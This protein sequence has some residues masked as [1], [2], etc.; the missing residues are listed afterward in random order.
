MGCNNGKASAP[1]PHAGKPA[2]AK[3]LLLGNEDPAASA[4]VATSMIMEVFTQASSLPG[5]SAGADE[6]E[7]NQIQEAH[8]A[9]DTYKELPTE[10]LHNALRLSPL[11]IVGVWQY[12]GKHHG[13][14]YEISIHGDNLQI[15]QMVS[16]TLLRGILRAEGEWLV[17]HVQNAEFFE[18]GTLRL[19]HQPQDR[20]QFGKLLSNFKVTGGQWGEDFMSS[21]AGPSSSLATSSSPVA[22]HGQNSS[23]TS[24][25]TAL[26]SSLATPSS[27]T[28]AQ[29]QGSSMTSPC[30]D[31]DKA[32][33]HKHNAPQVLPALNAGD[34]HRAGEA[35]AARPMDACKHSSDL[36]VLPARREKAMCCC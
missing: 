22:E 8:L 30:K 21:K 26:P 17:A 10:T 36:K 12:D 9:A 18:A 35:A 29:G 6:V 20:N 2:D 25:C 5:T 34:A 4:K 23:L 11:S 1:G 14:K 3:P 32:H 19:Q 15:E 27:S 24:P 7:P 13:S 31:K 33:P 28:S 16:N